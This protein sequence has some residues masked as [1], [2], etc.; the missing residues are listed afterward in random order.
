MGS[1][2]LGYPLSRFLAERGYK[3]KASTTS[4]SKIAAIERAGVEPV[5]L[6]VPTQSEDL[7]A[8]LS[9][10]DILIVN[11]PPSGAKGEYSRAAQQIVECL[12][13]HTKV[14]F[15]SSTSV[16][17]D[18]NRRVVEAD[19]H[20]GLGGND[21][22]LAAEHAFWKSIP[23]RTVILRCGGLI[24][25]KRIPGKYFAGKQGMRNGHILLNLVQREDIICVIDT[26]INKD[27][28]G[29]VWNLVAPGHRTRR[30]VYELNA[31]QFGFEAPQFDE[32]DLNLPFKIIDPSALIADLGYTFIYPD[33][34]Q[35]SYDPEED[36]FV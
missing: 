10:V 1:G 12:P 30:E 17:P 29:H 15:V 14:I 34:L 25:G 26:I 19:A 23:E 2:W 11:I 5:L 28:F 20:P 32:P 22:I 8:Q 27:A 21:E 13:A 16:Y 36:L 7:F 18:L 24:G 35:F 33:L 3:V 4:F 6:S 9:G 31:A